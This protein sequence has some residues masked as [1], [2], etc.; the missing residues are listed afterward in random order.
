MIPVKERPGYDQVKNYTAR[1][2]PPINIAWS[3]AFAGAS[4]WLADRDIKR[5]EQELLAPD[6]PSNNRGIGSF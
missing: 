4:A 6:N 5:A 2:E 3:D 1:F